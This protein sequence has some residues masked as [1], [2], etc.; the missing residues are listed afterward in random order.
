MSAPLSGSEHDV[1]EAVRIMPG[2]L[3]ADSPWTP[4][5]PDDLPLSRWHAWM[6]LVADREAGQPSP[7]HVVVDA[8]G[9]LLAARWSL[10][11]LAGPT[12]R[13]L[14]HRARVAAVLDGGESLIAACGLS[15]PWQRGDLDVADRELVPVVP[16]LLVQC[17]PCAELDPAEPS[18]PVHQWQGSGRAPD[19]A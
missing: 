12:E 3:G 17:A 1:V 6:D 8:L 11:W 14:L 2:L 9:G 7:R 5:E 13:R 16:D 18:R 19:P 15:K 4:A 10:W